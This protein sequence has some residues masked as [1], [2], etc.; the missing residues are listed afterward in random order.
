MNPV[1]TLP[2]SLIYILIL[3]SHLRLTGGSGQLVP[4]GS[5]P[6]LQYS[7][8][9]SSDFLAKILDVKNVRCIHITNTVVF[10]TVC[11]L[12]SPIIMTQAY[13]NFHFQFFPDVNFFSLH[14]HCQVIWFFFCIIIASML[15]L[16]HQNSMHVPLCR[17]KRHVLF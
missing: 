2:L 15:F 17:W 1:H 5:V 4:S 3:S 9:L 16:P 13:K 8:G 6:V 11:I 7:S 10:S 12:P 14:V